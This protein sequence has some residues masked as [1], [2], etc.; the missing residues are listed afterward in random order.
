M[1][2]LLDMQRGHELHI[3]APSDFVELWLKPRLPAFTREYPNARFNINGE[4]EAPAAH[5]ADG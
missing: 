5:R 2:A 4:G 1:A 3:A